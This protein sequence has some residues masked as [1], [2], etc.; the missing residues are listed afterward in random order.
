[1]VFANILEE[2]PIRKHVNS[3]QS[4]EWHGQFVDF[5]AGSSADSLPGRAV[6]RIIDKVSVY[7][8]V[9]LIARTNP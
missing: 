6:M 2:K 1:M 5:Q 8:H 7:M 9:K 3:A 4:E